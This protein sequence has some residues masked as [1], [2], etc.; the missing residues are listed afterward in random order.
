MTTNSLNQI[1][2]TLE[3]IDQFE[4]NL[5][6]IIQQGQG[7]VNKSVKNLRQIWAL[8]G[9]AT[10]LHRIRD[11]LQIEKYDL[12]FIGK[13]GAGKT[14][15]ICHLFNLL[16]YEKKIIDADGVKTEEQ[17]IKE[18]LSTGSGRT[19]I[20]EV[21]IRTAATSLI[22]I[23]PYDEKEVIQS[24]EI[25]CVYI[26]KRVHPNSQ[27]SPDIHENDLIKSD[28]LPAE[29]KRAVRNIVGL[30]EVSRQGTQIDEANELA[31]QFTRYAEFRDAVVDRANLPNRNVNILHYDSKGMTTIESQQVWIEENF[32]KINLC[33]LPNISIPRRIY[34]YLSP[35][36]LD[37]SDYPFKSIIDTRG[38]DEGK[39][40]QDLSNYIRDEDA[41]IC[42]FNE[43]F[44]DVPTNVIGLI[45]K[46]LT[47]ESKDIN[48][49]LAVMAMPRQGEP[50]KVM[51]QDGQV[52][53]KEEGIIVRTNQIK[54]SFEGQ[55]IAFLEDNI[56]FYDA[57]QFYDEEDRILKHRYSQ[58]HVDSDRDTTLEKFS[59][60]IANRKKCLAD[61]VSILGQLVKKIKGGELSLTDERKIEVLKKTI[62]QF[63]QTNFAFRLKDEFIKTL[64]DRHVMVFRAINNR[65][66]IYEYRGIDIF[67]DAQRVAEELVRKRFGDPKSEIVGAIKNTEEGA[68]DESGLRP[69]LEVL[70]SQ[71]DTFY[72]N[73]AIKIGEEIY[74]LMKDNI[75]APL[76]DSNEFWEI[77]HR[78]WGQG[79]GYKNDVLQMYRGNLEFVDDF[80]KDKAEE[81]WHSEFMDKILEFFTED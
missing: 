23:D 40:R 13:V 20:C 75:F 39:D 44:S 47:P 7:R 59:Q 80:L 28:A 31:K 21:V 33:S 66:G 18:I 38:I 73:L 43:K 11:L 67:F 76:D 37:L 30:R 3:E 35:E 45:G 27:E 42:I 34:V 8:R 48:T 25:F 55:N 10:R 72:E 24:I 63:Q 2:L 22:E 77:I 5:N 65:C 52:A 50:K 26:W 61:E 46:Y 81:L 68:S 1:A 69:V 71:I 19:T 16:R 60:L 79:R 70:R 51:G 78:R 9:I 41:T 57:L 12:A 17:A 54:D 74:E 29:L 53:S 58:K 56:L 15:A 62:N 6:L 4:E 14:T 64:E 36:I 32:N 49:K